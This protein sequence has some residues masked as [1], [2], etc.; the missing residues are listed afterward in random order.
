MAQRT[1]DASA[2]SD[3]GC[4]FIV[5]ASLA[6]LATLSPGMGVNSEAERT[7]DPCVKPVLPLCPILRSGLGTLPQREADWAAVGRC[8]DLRD[9]TERKLRRC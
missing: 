6:S 8:G 5:F 7:L 1:S 4:G 3:A 2:A 9:S